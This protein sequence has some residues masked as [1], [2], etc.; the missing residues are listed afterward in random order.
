MREDLLQFIWR[1]KTVLDKPL[2]LTSGCPVT[3]IN[4]GLLNTNQGPDFLFAQIQIDGIIWSGHVEIHVKSSDWD[5]HRHDFDPNYQN[6]ILH[7]VWDHDQ[8]VHFKE[9][10][11]PCLELKNYVD[12]LVLDRYNKLM[13]QSGS[14][15][16]HSFLDGISTQLKTIQLERMMVERLEYK[17]EKITSELLKNQWDWEELF[18]RKLAHYLVAPVNSD[19]MDSLT[20]KISRQLA[21]KNCSDLIELQS[22]FFGVSGLLS[23]PCQDDYFK[24]LC[25]NFIHQ[26]LKYNLEAMDAFQWKLLRLRPAHFPSLRIAQL[27]A[28]LYKSPHLFSHILDAGDL[29]SISKLMDVS[30][31][32]YWQDHV[33]FSKRS[34]HKNLAS[35]GK[36]TKEILIINVVIP[37]LFAYGIV[38]QKPSVCQRALDWIQS[39]KAEKN[40][41]VYMWKSFNFAMDHAGQSQGGIQ[42]YRSYCIEKKCSSC[43]IGNEI[44]N[45]PMKHV[46][47]SC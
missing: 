16:C 35:I 12:Q 37:F 47:H 42:L 44:L 28:L 31:G 27:T 30:P 13:N 5:A 21:L 24:I 32:I 46:H 7:I 40:N 39:L 15:A 26:Q 8:D 4:P 33:G 3:V 19:A 43:L 25:M 18:Y 10:I 9:R 45:H 17:T 11:L 38:Q 29:K 14:I 2:H 23:S 6:I 20:T 34:K 22:L 36:H 41:I 1:S